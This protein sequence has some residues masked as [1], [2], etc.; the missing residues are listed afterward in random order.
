MAYAC[1]YVSCR[2]GLCLCV[3]AHV[4]LDLFR[5]R[6]GAKG[7][8]WVETFWRVLLLLPFL[9]VLIFYGWHFVMSAWI[10]DEGTRFYR[11]R[12]P[13]VYQVLSMVGFFLLLFS[14]VTADGVEI[15]LWGPEEL[16]A[17]TNQT[18]LRGIPIPLL[19][20][21][22]EPL[23]VLGPKPKS[24]DEVRASGRIPPVDIKSLARDVV[25]P[26]RMPKKRR[27]LRHRRPGQV[28][29]GV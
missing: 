21:K 24:S 9:G 3:N 16:A 26:R 5:P 4:R 8:L 19:N 11:N 7:R 15:R 1:R 20:R 22:L 10:T 23:R 17:A 18:R 27:H 25:G 6:L 14:P 28:V 12:Q 29:S 13:V 2:D